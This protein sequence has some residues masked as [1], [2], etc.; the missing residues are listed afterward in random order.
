MVAKYGEFPGKPVVIHKKEK[1][2]K[3]NSNTIKMFCAECGYEMKTTRKM[4]EK[5]GQK[6]PTCVC[7]AKMALDLEDEEENM[8]TE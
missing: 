6:L 4:F 3:G 8:D 7:G 2:E 1:G 5:H